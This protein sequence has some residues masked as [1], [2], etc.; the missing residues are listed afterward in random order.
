MTYNQFS[1]YALTGLSAS[2]KNFV[3]NN[4]NSS[5]SEVS[6]YPNK[7]DIFVNKENSSIGSFS[8]TE[9]HTLDQING[10][11]LYLD[12]RPTVDV[13]G[14]VSAF[15][16]SDGGIIDP[17]QTDIYSSTVQFTVLPVAS[18]FTVSYSASSDKVQDSHINAIQNTL[19]NVESVLGIKS[20]A[21]GQGTG[22][23]S[24]PL[25][26]NATISSLSEYQT[27][28]TLL[29]NIVFP[30]HLSNNFK[31]GSTNVVGVPGY[32]TGVT[33]YIGNNSAASRDSV[34][35]DANS[36]TLSTTNGLAGN[37]GG[38][39]NIGT[40]TGDYVNMS[41]CLTVASQ[42][43]IGLVGGA[44]GTVNM[45][46]PG[47][48][49]AFYTGAMLRVHGGIW[50]GSG[51]S[52]NG[53][54]TF[55]TTTGQAVDVQGNLLATTLDVSTTSQFHGASTFLNTV[56]A[57]Y[58]GQYTTNNDIVL[59]TKPNLTPAKIDGLDPSYAQYA[60]DNPVVDCKI[61]S[62]VR[63][64]IEIGNTTPYISGYKQH[65]VYGFKMYPIIGGWAYTGLVAYEKAQTG[66][67]KNIVLLNTNLT[68]IGINMQ[69][70]VASYSGVNIGNGTLNYGDY[71]TGLF[72]PGDTYIE[73]K[74]LT[75][76]DDYTYPIY[77]H[78][79]F[80]NSNILTGIN[81]YLAAD[82]SALQNSIAGKK[83]R[84]YQPGNAPLNHLSGDF[85]TPSAPLG[86]VGNMSTDDYPSSSLAVIT[87]KAWLG[88]SN[89]SNNNAQYK[90][91]SS[92]ATVSLAD[93]L[94]KNI[95][96]TGSSLNATGVAYIYIA[97]S[98]TNSTVESSLQL[99]ASPTPYGISTTQV[100]NGT[101][102][103]T[104][105]QHIPIGEIVA[106]TNDGTSWTYVESASYR[107][108]G[109][110]DSCWI[111]LVDY[112]K[113]A[114]QIPSSLGRCLPFYTSTASSSTNY[115]GS[116]DSYIY[117]W[118]VEHNIGPVESLVNLNYRVYIA[119]YGALF[120]T[121]PTS[122]GSTDN[123]IF[124]L[125]SRGNQNL[126]SQYPGKYAT[127]H[128]FYKASNG[129]R[130]FLKDITDQCEL[131]YNDTRFAAFGTNISIAD[132]AG[133]NNKVAQYIR[134]VIKK[135]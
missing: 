85:S 68:A 43:T 86:V 13:T 121:N 70:G 61:V 54:I 16:I 12:H 42:T 23:V 64:P 94:Q 31:L 59:N 118:F 52:G 123:A 24:L 133:Q 45:T 98:E 62:S 66:S 69:S 38:T 100:Q 10:T 74:G 47:A 8:V 80:I 104:P 33:I 114:S 20:T 55:V 116:A 40:T 5:N 84:I 37:P 32:G 128:A 107:P 112:R 132:L 106:T 21:G 35:I 18:P 97:G 78:Q 92:T 111:P 83:Y 29:P 101:P 28:Q 56:T 90:K 14:G 9:Q 134:V 49:G 63:P 26:T 129:S 2:V 89:V 1:S 22:L 7:F 4:S 65:P 71:C 127:S 81:L 75:A 48:A 95:G 119:S 120:G 96:M 34:V 105:G 25:V 122:S 17:S 115:D 36:F 109:M 6:S 135:N 93:A 57:Q 19:M 79:S 53:S 108:D 11:M 131:I 124:K 99:R 60:I 82:D 72:N 88:G 126:W 77:Y 130:G 110:Y 67:Y 87:D 91:V 15:V 58:P 39:Y 73:F 117:Q 46:V 125:S 51:M 102:K 30:A 113:T 76:A 44:K 3:D 50:F 27:L 103:L 41:G